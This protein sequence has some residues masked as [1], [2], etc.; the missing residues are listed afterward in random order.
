MIKLSLKQK[1]SLLAN[2]VIAVACLLVTLLSFML[3][4][5]RLD[6]EIQSRLQ[7][8]TLSYNNYV[9]DWLAAKGAALSAIPSNI[10]TE[11][12]TEHLSQARDSAQFDNV[13]IAFADGTS[14]NAN[15]IVLPADNNDP[16]QWGW[17]KNAIA[18]PSSVFMDNPTIAA[19]TGANVVSLGKVQRINGEQVVLGADVELTDILNQLKKVIL[20]G[21]NEM[22]IATNTGHVF[23]YKNM[24]LLNESVE[25]IRT[26]L[27]ASMLNNLA[28]SKIV[29]SQY[30]SLH[31]Q[32]EQAYIYVAPIAGTH[33]Y[34]VVIVDYQS[35]VA[36]LLNALYS[37]AMVSFLAIIFCACLLNVVCKA[38]FKPLD[39]V[40]SIL[41]IIAQGSGD[42]TQR[43]NI[44]THDEVGKLA[45]HFNVF[46]ASLQALIVHIRGQALDL[47]QQA[48]VS[49]HQ[50]EKSVVELEAQQQ[51]VR[52]VVTAITEMSA[53]TKEIASHAERTAETVNLS[54]KQI[55]EGKTLVVKT[56]TSINNLAVEINQATRVIGELHQHAKTIDSILSTIQNIAEQTNLLAL[57]AAIEAAR[58]GDQGRGFAVVADEVR[59]LS[60]R[61]YSSTEEI[62]AMINTL[63]Q[64][65]VKAVDIMGVSSVFAHNAVEH[66]EQAATAIE[67]ISGSIETI[68]EMTIQVAASAE[69]Q[70][71][72]TDEI[73]R[74]CVAIQDLAEAI[75]TDAQYSQ[76]QFDHLNSQAGRLNQKVSTFIVA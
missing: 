51:E 76:Q 57:N 5:E 29:S 73:M 26:A 33:L 31:D 41:S 11:H 25:H 48:K 43:I 46:V 63:Q 30:L 67:K 23:A 34:T 62:Q 10:N 45:S 75:A 56:S 60:Q 6:E 74:N 38:L 58:A 15:G 4:K 65:T 49:A 3:S 7:N 19:A 1:I 54:S 28:E 61:T 71:V 12:I 52:L 36:P 59:V 40:S 35:V 14:E 72:V 13:F 47:E 37:Q 24:S 17:Y 68:N 55:A 66:S 64:S 9:V 42:L 53:A 69:E 18:N 16:R 20:P 70:N 44:N 21:D 27:T 50:S 2:T 39:K 8:V 22:F 32:N